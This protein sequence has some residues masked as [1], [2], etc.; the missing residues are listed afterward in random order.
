MSHPDVITTIWDDPRNV[1]TLKAMWSDGASAAE[2]ARALGQGAT[3]SAV[4]GKVH[5]LKLQKRDNAIRAKPSKTVNGREPHKGR[6][7][8][9]GQ[10]KGPDIVRRVEGRMKAER[11][12][13][14]GKHSHA[15]HEPFRPGKLPKDEGG[16]DVTHT[17]GRDR[18]I[19][20]ECG[21]VKGEPGHGDWGY[22]GKPT[23]MGTEWCAEHHARV[24]PK[25]GQ[26]NA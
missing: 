15:G 17:I 13:Q 5:R 10:S 14:E 20:H 24:Y 11:A 26:S 23:V 6:S 4:I 1:D 7:G 19:G 12:R 25:L 16:V 8:G 3:R 9:V 22:C 21:W 18:K 2:I